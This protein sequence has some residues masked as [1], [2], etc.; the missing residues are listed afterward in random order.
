MMVLVLVIFRI[1]K[2]NELC[3]V[4]FYLFI[5]LSFC[6]REGFVVGLL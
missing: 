3:L 4:Y 6:K 2:Y 5:M 1:E